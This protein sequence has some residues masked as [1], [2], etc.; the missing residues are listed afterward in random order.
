[1]AKYSTE[2]KLEVVN[3]YLS[4]YTSYNDVAKHFDIPSSTSIKRWVSK[5]KEHGSKGLLKNFHTSYDGIFKQNVVEYMHTNH[6]S[7]NQTANHFNLGC[8]KIV[9]DW[10]CIYYKEGPQGLYKEELRGS[11]KTMKSDNKKKKNTKEEDLVAEVERLRMENAYLKKLQ[12]LI[13]ERTKP[14]HP[15]K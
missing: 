8:E 13:Q 5:Y 6:L 7:Y 10:E 4:N 9:K 11:K 14:K 2:F 12:A 3:Y 1:M 15:K